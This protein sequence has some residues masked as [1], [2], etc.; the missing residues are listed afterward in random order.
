MLKNY[1]H[2][3]NIFILLIKFMNLKFLFKHSLLFTLNHLIGILDLTHYLMVMDYPIILFIVNS[4]V[5][6][7]IATLLCLESRF[8][9]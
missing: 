8:L 7:L 9:R 3:H 1:I 4:F 5:I 2:D 6:L